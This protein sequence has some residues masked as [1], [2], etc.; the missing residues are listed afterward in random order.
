MITRGKFIVGLL[1]VGLLCFG[2][3][4]L[5]SNVFTFKKADTQSVLLNSIALP[6]A[7]SGNRA[8]TVV[9]LA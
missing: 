4:K 2:I 1:L 5:V 8:N 9:P 6:T 3:N 7:T